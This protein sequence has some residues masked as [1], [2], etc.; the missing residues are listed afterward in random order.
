MI[1]T[2]PAALTTVMATAHPAL[3]PR[4]RRAGRC[5]RSINAAIFKPASAAPATSNTRRSLG[6]RS[7]QRRLS[8]TG[9]YAP[10]AVRR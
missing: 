10:E 1:G 4:T 8:M 5:A 9:M 7:L 3:E 6:S 2:A